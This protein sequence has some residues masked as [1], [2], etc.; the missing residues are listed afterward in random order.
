MKIK[1][2]ALLMMLL[3]IVP[4][5]LT[6]C[7]GDGDDGDGGNNPGTTPCEH[8]DADDDGKCDECG[9]SFDDGE[10]LPPEDEE[11]TDHVDIDKNGICDNEGCDHVVSPSLVCDSSDSPNGAHRDV[12]D[13]WYCDYCGNTFEDGEDAGEG[14]CAHRDADDNGRCDYCGDPFNDLPEPKTYNVTWDTTNLIF[15]MTECSNHQELPSTCKRYLAGD[16]EGVDD[17]GMIDTY[18]S[19]RNRA[20]LDATGVEITYTYL[21]D[22]SDKYGWGCNIETIY[23]EV[24]GQSSSRPDIYCN[25]VYD[26]VATSLKGS[27]ANLMSS[28][29]GD[30][31]FEF[32]E[33]DFVD[34]GE[35]Y[36]YTYMRSLTLNKFKMY[37]VSS[38]YFTDMVRA[39]FVVP[40]N[41]DVMESQIDVDI[42]CFDPDY[43]PDAAT[44]YNSDRDGDQEFTI[45]DFYDLVWDGQWN[46][47]IL[48][49]Y[50]SD[51]YEPGSQPNTTGNPHG[52]LHDTL[53]FAI[54]CSSGL[55]ASGML[56]TTTV[57][58]IHN[59][60]DDDISD[61]KYYYPTENTELYN[62]AENMYK[63]FNNTDGAI[64]ITN[65]EDLGYGLGDGALVAIREQFAE[66]QILFGG[67]ICLGSLEY[68]TYGKMENGFGLAPAPLYRDVNPATGEPDPYQTQIHN[69]GRVGAISATTTKFPQC[70]AYLDYQ[71]LNSKKVLDEYYNFK[72][73]YDIAG[74]GDNI[75]MLQYIRKNVRSS[76]DKAFEDALG[77]FFKSTDEN[78]DNN[79]WHKILMDNGFLVNGS[80]M[81][82]EYNK[83]IGTKIGYL[84]QLQAEYDVL[85][86]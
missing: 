40:V 9:T 28:T 71:S 46:Y 54:S 23:E 6:A 36:M 4:F 42:D 7:D 73:Q 14:E 75:A 60:W 44:K 64:A 55:S 34:H 51:V 80:T 15:Q 70:T 85:P 63:F 16:T 86:D 57:K 59:D 20:A 79:K 72:L 8:V 74:G 66:G 58:V 81:L 24:Y 48:A 77:R 17:Y 39:F 3:M 29:R 52:C 13:D 45:D 2:L 12:D 67:I 35:G 82:T 50:C 19:E 18:V 10:D 65:E 78:S 27:F 84:E 68:E 43:D 21:A 56:Y 38:D 69:I 41:I 22:D 30:N 1:I 11:C 76:F 83:L 5:V 62:F 47:E 32:L 37:C 33:D 61:F 25:F 31:F 26:M 49:E 53:G